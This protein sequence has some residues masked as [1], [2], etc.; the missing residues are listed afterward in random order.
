[1]DVK[2]VIVTLLASI[3]TTPPLPITMDS[4]DLKLVIV[5]LS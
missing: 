2:L 4:S 3:Y 5:T 1:M